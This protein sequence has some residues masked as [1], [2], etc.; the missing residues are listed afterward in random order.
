MVLDTEK[1][2]AEKK[3]KN[4]IENER[5]GAIVERYKAER[6]EKD[7]EELYNS[8]YA[9][10]YGR[11][12]ARSSGGSDLAEEAIQNGFMIFY[13][14]PEKVEN[15]AAFYGWMET[16][17]YHEYLA[18][19]RKMHINDS[20]TFEEGFQP[21]PQKEGIHPGAVDDT[22]DFPG[23]ELAQ[24]ELTNMLLD[25][26]KELPEMQKIAIFSYYY[27]NRSIKE[28]AEDIAVPENT[29]KSYLSRGKKAM[30]KRIGSYAGARGLRMAP[31]AIF[32]F[33]AALCSEEVQACERAVTPEMTKAAFTSFG[34]MAGRAAIGTVSVETGAASAGKAAAT[35]AAGQ[36]LGV[37]VA[38]VVAA[39]TIAGGGAFVAYKQSAEPVTT[40]TATTEKTIQEEEPATETVAEPEPKGIVV[41]YSPFEAITAGLE[42]DGYRFLDLDGDGTKEL[43]VGHSLGKDNLI[44]FGA[45]T[46]SSTSMWGE[47]YELYAL[48]EGEVVDV[49]TYNMFWEDSSSLKNIEASSIEYFMDNIESEIKEGY[50]YGHNGEKLDV[51]LYGRDG[52]AITA[53]CGAAADIIS[54]PVIIKTDGT[55]MIGYTYS[56][57]EVTQSLT[58]TWPSYP[59]VI[60]G[61]ITNTLTGKSVPIETMYTMMRATSYSGLVGSEPAGYPE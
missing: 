61:T 21:E 37:K 58:T 47:E 43:F 27:D 55:N 42:E 16:T 36:A 30:N 32:P 31:L 46:V 50:G 38:A 56:D 57:G 59:G 6:S 8:T 10:L 39:A 22:I 41:D 7:F 23:E 40:E 51:S 26:M 20:T 25:A 49:G 24:K 48:K 17:C 4:A 11:L 35:G 45:Y 12:Q 54:Y 3:K 52:D 53:A 28:I 5:L 18:I 13:K 15:G 34:L 14:D 44:K 19:I 2:R 29:V 33:M 9:S 60:D 1:E